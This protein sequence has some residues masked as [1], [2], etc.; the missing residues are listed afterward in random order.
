LSGQ[1]ASTTMSQL[2]AQIN[3]QLNSKTS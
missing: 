1:S 3:S 2:A